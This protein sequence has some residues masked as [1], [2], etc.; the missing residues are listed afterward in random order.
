MR[1]L[2]MAKIEKPFYAPF[3]IHRV[4]QLQKSKL[5]TLLQFVKVKQP[6]QPHVK[7]FNFSWKAPISLQLEIY[8]QENFV[9]CISIFMKLFKAQSFYV[10]VLCIFRISKK[11]ELSKQKLRRNLILWHSNFRFIMVWMWP[12]VRH[13]F[14]I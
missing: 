13:Q 11:A 8:W 14:F 7:D 3:F 12:C 5:P 10:C 6:Y 9:N 2:K 1:F 4:V